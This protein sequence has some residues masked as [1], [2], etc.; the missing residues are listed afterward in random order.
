V[1]SFKDHYR[2]FNKNGA[3]VR[4]RHESLGHTLAAQSQFVP[5]SHKTVAKNEKIQSLL[6]KT[7]G[8]IVLNNR[9]IKQVEHEFNLKYAS[10]E[11]KKLG[12]TGITL[13]FDPTIGKAVLEK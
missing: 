13:R 3:R 6:R 8:R 10:T 7:T 5:D 11:P 4:K 12:N 9:D 2:K 1:N